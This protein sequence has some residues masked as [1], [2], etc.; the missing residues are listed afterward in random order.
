MNI[1]W[2]GE[3]KEFIVTGGVVLTALVLLPSLE[4]HSTMDPIFQSLIVSAV[5]FLVL[6]L[7]YCKI[8]LKQPW[9]ALGLRKG[10]VWAG[11]GGSLVAL[12]SGLVFLFGLI[13]F[14]PVFDRMYLPR[15]VEESFFLFL[16]YE[17]V[18]NG[19]ITLLIEVFFRGLVMFVWLRS[20]GFLS[21]LIQA[22]LFGGFL[23]LTN[24]ITPSMIPLLL[25]SP[26]AGLIAYQ[27]RS[28][29]ASW[30]ASWFFVFLADVLILILGK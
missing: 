12:V 2:F 27:S 11:L 7:L 22:G 15:A 5:L 3:R 9:S 16:L 24:D 17:V 25:F 20:L 4:Q 21:V 29:F 23:Y 14:T 13:H 26:L 8:V 30:G 1:E 18:L 10:S 28:I 19:W 6:P